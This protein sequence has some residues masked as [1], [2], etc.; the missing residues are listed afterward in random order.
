M[1]ILLAIFRDAGIQKFW[2][3]YDK[4]VPATSRVFPKVIFRQFIVTHD[5]KFKW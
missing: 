2:S 4:S 3:H 1:I 5:E